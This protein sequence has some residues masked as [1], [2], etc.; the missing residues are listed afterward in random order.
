MMY[1]AKPCMRELRRTSMLMRQRVSTSLSQMCLETSQDLLYKATGL[2]QVGARPFASASSCT[3]ICWKTGTVPFYMSIGLVPPGWPAHCLHISFVAIVAKVAH[4]TICT[5]KAFAVTGFEQWAYIVIV[6]EMASN[7]VLLCTVSRSAKF[8]ELVL[9]RVPEVQETIDP[10]MLSSVKWDVLPGY[11]T[12]KEQA[13]AFL[14]VPR[15]PVMSR[16]A[17]A[18]GLLRVNRFL[19]GLLERFGRLHP[20]QLEDL[21]LAYE[22]WA[23]VVAF[24]HDPTGT[25]RSTS[26]WPCSGSSAYSRSWRLCLWNP[27]SRSAWS[28]CSRIPSPT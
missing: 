12:P 28:G 15:I 18:F 22:R 7:V 16:A 5:Y 24:A 19:V 14:M 23:C 2:F 4:M 10:E 3:S 25:A 17:W 21:D 13:S 6:M 27:V 20:F 8:R 1:C 9:G 26:T 11:I